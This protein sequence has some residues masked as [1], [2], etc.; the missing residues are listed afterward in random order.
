MDDARRRA[1][2]VDVLTRKCVD[3][4]LARR[5]HKCIGSEDASLAAPKGSGLGLTTALPQ[6]FV[7]AEGTGAHDCTKASRT[8]QCGTAQNPR[9]RHDGARR[10]ESETRYLTSDGF[11]ATRDSTRRTSRR[12]S[13]LCSVEARRVCN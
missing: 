3:G 10:G 13:G 5:L 2:E 9:R 11:E 7:V 4:R 6:Q 12:C 8:V 1:C